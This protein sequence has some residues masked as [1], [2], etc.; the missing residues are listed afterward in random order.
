MQA[1]SK[2]RIGMNGGQ[3]SSF[4]NGKVYGSV[5]FFNL[6]PGRIERALCIILENYISPSM[7]PS[8]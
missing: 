8:G 5:D 4:L 2:N 6:N 1:E 3:F 7:L